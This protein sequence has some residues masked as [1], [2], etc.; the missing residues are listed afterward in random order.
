[1]GDIKD[2]R[3]LY[4]KGLLFLLLG[5]LSVGLLLALHPSLTVAL[6]LGVAIW[7]FARAY[8]FKTT[9]RNRESRP[10]WVLFA[11]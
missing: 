5:G 2:V 3:L 8:Y 10:G 9:G 4:L 6:L 7:A 11:D 1:M